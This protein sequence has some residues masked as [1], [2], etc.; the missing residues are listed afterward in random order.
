LKQRGRKGLTAGR[1][2]KKRVG[3]TDYKE[4]PEAEEKHSQSAASASLSG[5]P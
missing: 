2:L 3:F 1:K 4:E 5:R